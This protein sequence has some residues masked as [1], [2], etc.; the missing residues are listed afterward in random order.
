MLPYPERNSFEEKLLMASDTDLQELL[1]GG[2]ILQH[3]LNR[4]CPREVCYWLFQIMCQHNDHHIINAAFQVLWAMI[5]A[6][7]E[8]R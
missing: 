8:V 5:E 4:A 3:Y 7:T 6:A 2:W 1:C